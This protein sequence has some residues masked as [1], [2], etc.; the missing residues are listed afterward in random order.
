MTW[1][2]ITSAWLSGLALACWVLL[3]LAAH[4]VWHDTGRPDVWHLEG[5]P[6]ADLRAF[7]VTFY[8][9]G[10]VLVA[11]TL[12]SVVGFKRSSSGRS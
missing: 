8:V 9:L 5:P 7:V 4:D 3:F 1:I 2:R 11:L 12:A 10:A 6:Y